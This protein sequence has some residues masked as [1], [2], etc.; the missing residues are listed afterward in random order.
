[1]RNGEVAD[2]PPDGAARETEL[3]Q[4]RIQIE[5]QAAT[6][7]A[8]Q[9]QITDLR[10]QRA[11]PQPGFLARHS[12]PI[13]A[14][15]AVLLIGLV[16]VWFTQTVTFAYR[17]DGHGM[18]P[19]LHDGQTLLVVQTA[20]LPGGLQRGDLI[21]FE[22]PVDTRLYVKRVIALPSEIVQI[23]AGDG[24]Y[25]NDTKINEP[26]IKEAPNYNY[27]PLVVPTDQFFVLGDNQNNS[28]DSH[29]FGTIKLSAI[30]G[31]VG[32]SP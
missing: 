7:A 26:Y 17:V 3:R 23:K 29:G 13:V 12:R 22:P 6:I 8:L 4:A 20:F 28:A 24:V 15:L 18:E 14:L 27:G 9:Q 25:I 5:Q 31:R 32:F 21:A 10:R 2:P 19:T 16:A 1:M 30:A 11:P